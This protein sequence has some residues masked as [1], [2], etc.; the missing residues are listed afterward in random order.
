[1]AGATFF[2]KSDLLKRN[3]FSEVLRSSVDVE[4]FRS[5]L[6]KSLN[7]MLADDFN[8]TVFRAADKSHH[9][10]KEDDDAL[11]RMALPVSR[12]EINV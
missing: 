4:F 11:L 6:K 1:M 3:P 5:A 12:K 9:T 10:W 2:G 8:F 7:V